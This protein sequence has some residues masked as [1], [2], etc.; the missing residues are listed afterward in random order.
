MITP[1]MARNLQENFDLEEKDVV[2]AG[3]IAADVFLRRPGIKF[4]HLYGLVEGLAE[5]P[6]GAALS[7]ETEIK[8]SGY[9]KRQETE[10]KQ[11]SHRESLELPSDLDY[12]RIQGLT[13]E[14]V[15]TLSAKKPSSLGQ[16]GRLQGV[17]PATISALTIYIKKINRRSPEKIGPETN[18]ETV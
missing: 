8:F 3:P 5:M 17:T 18:P 15:E 10:L 6:P 9:L 13:T 12:S 11:K 14:A 2:L 16:A 4:K 1:E 7:L